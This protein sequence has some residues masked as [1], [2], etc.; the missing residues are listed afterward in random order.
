[1]LHLNTNFFS[2]FNLKTS[3]LI[4][5]SMIVLSTLDSGLSS[6]PNN[7]IK[8]NIIET[9]DHVIVVKNNSVVFDYLQTED[10]VESP[11][12]LRVIE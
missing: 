2:I 11:V 3:Q 8:K 6:I 10:D 4:S 1:M 9:T 5:L 12:H 7:S